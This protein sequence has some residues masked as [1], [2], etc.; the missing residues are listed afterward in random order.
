MTPPVPGTVDAPHFQS[1][2]DHGTKLRRNLAGKLLNEPGKR[3]REC[4]VVRVEHEDEITNASAVLLETLPSSDG[5]W[6]MFELRAQ[7][8]AWAYF[9][10]C[11]RPI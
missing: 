2:W 11:E 10:F 7:H 1:S 9:N 5:R 8:I 4:V 3:S 6:L